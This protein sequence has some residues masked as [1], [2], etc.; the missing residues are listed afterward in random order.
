MKSN[1]K[2]NRIRKF[3]QYSNTLGGLVGL[4]HVYRYI[5]AA[6]ISYNIIPYF[7]DEIYGKRIEDIYYIKEY[8]S[9]KDNSYGFHIGIPYYKF[10][11]R[12]INMPSPSSYA[13]NDHHLDFYE[14]LKENYRWMS[15]YANTKE[16]REQY[17]LKLRELEKRIIEK[18]AQDAEKT[19]SK[20]EEAKSK[21]EE[22]ESL[23]NHI[24]ESFNSK[25]QNK[26]DNVFRLKKLYEESESATAKYLCYLIKESFY[27]FEWSSQPDIE[28]N[29]NNRVAI[30]E[31]YLPTLEECPNVKEYDTSKE[32]KLLSQTA[33]KK[34]YEELI[35]KI[36]LRTIA[37]IFH[38][39]YLN[40]ISM[41]CFNG[42]VKVRNAGTGKMEDNCILSLSI[43][44]EEFNNVELRYVDAKACFKHLKGVGGA[45]LYDYSPIVPIMQMSKD[46]KRFVD[47]HNVTTDSSTN[48]AAMD[49]EE[50]EH[51]V[52]EL[53]D[54]EF[55]NNGGEVK[56]TQASRDGGVDAIAF[57]PDPIR[58]GKIII[59][60]KRY[61]N[62]VSV[63]AVRDLYG[64]VINEGANKGILITTSDYGSDSYNFAK[65]KP[66][67]LLN[68]GHLLY[69][70]EKHGKKA[71]ID[72]EQ[73]KQLSK[74]G[75][76]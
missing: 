74:H 3:S 68:G 15:L 46:D 44:R 9:L 35:Y 22:A 65:G 8:D 54:M 25:Q 50:F 4:N 2:V 7:L 30:I 56:I 27:L 64:T 10:K 53:F 59:Q 12:H 40:R 17:K 71:Y 39:D 21:R 42:R 73:A 70:L 13:E 72:I 62:T 66:I 23:Y 52:R 43:R 61:T 26:V 11:K 48:L 51:L 28:Y 5:E 47:S 33:L 34:L 37:E 38:Y 1:L 20:R 58:G 41:I 36:T 75:V 14:N 55:N 29:S 76:N 67:T 32:D 63:S 49:W 24:A 16:E 57:D 60:A 45:K 18:S 69:L 6:R 31:Y 19:K